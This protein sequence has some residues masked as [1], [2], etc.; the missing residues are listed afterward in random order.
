M[1]SARSD[2]LKDGD[3]TDAQLQQ[4]DGVIQLS[5]I[6]SNSDAMFEVVEMSDACFVHLL[7]KYAPHVVNR[8]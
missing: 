6:G 4:Y 7:L 2:K 3:A 1:A 5:L 8:I